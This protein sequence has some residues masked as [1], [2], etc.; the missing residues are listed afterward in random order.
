MCRRPSDTACLGSSWWPGS[1]CLVGDKLTTKAGVGWCWRQR[2]AESLLPREAVPGK[3]VIEYG[4]KLQRK[5]VPG[6]F[7]PK[8]VETRGNMGVPAYCVSVSF[9]RKEIGKL[10]DIKEIGGGR[11][12]NWVWGLLKYISRPMMEPLQPGVG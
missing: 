7:C 10:R 11:A 1:L 9:G 6:L 12:K 5:G 4:H 2:T 3:E 8:A